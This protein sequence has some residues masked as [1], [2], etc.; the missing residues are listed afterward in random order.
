MDR[1]RMQAA[2]EYLSSYTWML[3]VVSVVVVVAAL[4]GVFYPDYFIG[5]TCAFPS[6]FSCKSTVLTNNGILYVNI[7][8]TTGAP[9]SI[10]YISCNSNQTTLYSASYSTQVSP[11]LQVDNGANSSFM[12]QCYQAATPFHATIGTVYNGYLLVTYTNL[13]SGLPH[14]QTA[15]VNLK[16]ASGPLSTT[17]VTTTTSTTS[18]SSTTS[19]PVCG[20]GECYPNPPGC[21]GNC[22]S[23]CS[24]HISC[25]NGHGIECTT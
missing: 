21:S 17:T 8:Q 19:I 3:I 6:G 24:S 11:A 15:Q 7:Q 18:T 20:C 5:S 22:P 14:T 1:T 16:V 12:L 25:A 2:M 23:Q 4:I 10:T 13:A 9:I